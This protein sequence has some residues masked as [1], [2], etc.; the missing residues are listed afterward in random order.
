MLK[1]LTDSSQKRARTIASW[2]CLH[3]LCRHHGVSGTERFETDMSATSPLVNDRQMPVKDVTRDA[4][5]VPCE[6]DWI[7]C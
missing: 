6:N 3:S 4:R 7:R 5:I 1:I 2:P